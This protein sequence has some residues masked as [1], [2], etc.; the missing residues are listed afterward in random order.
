LEA[1]FTAADVAKLAN[2][3]GEWVSETDRMYAETLRD[4]LFPKITSANQTVTAKATG[5]RLKRHVGAPVRYNGE[6][7][8]LKKS[9]DP[10]ANALRYYVETCSI[11][12]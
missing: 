12:G 7:L 8:T 2:T 10:H 5:R 4:F 3:T 9:P 1:T 6:V 11:P